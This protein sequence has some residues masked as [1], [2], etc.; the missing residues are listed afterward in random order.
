MHMPVGQVLFVMAP[1][2]RVHFRSVFE[3]RLQP[4]QSGGLVYAAT[5]P[6]IRVLKY[7]I[8]SFPQSDPLAAGPRPPAAVADPPIRPLFR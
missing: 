7:S 1:P 6:R 3:G 4:R 5:G 2:A 8:Q